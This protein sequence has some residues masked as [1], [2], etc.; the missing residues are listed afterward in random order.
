MKKHTPFCPNKDAPLPAHITI[1]INETIT[2]LPPARRTR[3]NS[4]S[5]VAPSPSPAVLNEEDEV[6]QQL[7]HFVTLP[8]TIIVPSEVKTL[9]SELLESSNFTSV[10]YAF[11]QLVNASLNKKPSK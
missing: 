7:P 3:S 4:G 10:D 2:A 5:Q 6:Q 8:T 11:G 9:L 1:D